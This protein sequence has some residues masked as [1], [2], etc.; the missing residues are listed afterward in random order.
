MNQSIKNEERWDEGKRIRGKDRLPYGLVFQYTLRVEQV[1]DRYTLC[2]PAHTM[3]T[4]CT[5][6]VY[7]RYTQGGALTPLV[8]DPLEG[9][10]GRG[11]DGARG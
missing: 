4:Q 3:Y 10:R 5:L 1:Y 9:K 2:V 6:K 7:S 11:V 8:G